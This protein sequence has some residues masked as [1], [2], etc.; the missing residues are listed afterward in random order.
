MSGI[1]A[2]LVETVPAAVPM[3]ICRH[4]VE[5]M[6]GAPMHPL[7]A[8]TEVVR[9]GRRL[10]VVRASLFDADREVARSMSVRLR[11]SETATPFDAERMRHTED[12]PPELPDGSST[13]TMP[14]SGVPKF[15]HG[16]ELR[17]PG[18]AFRTGAPGLL[19]L[20][21]HC[22]LVEGVPTSPYVRLAAVGDMLSMVAG[23]LDPG[24][25]LTIN[26][27]LD[28]HTFRDPVGE[29]IG[30]RGLH[31]TVGDGI[32]LSEAV[33]YDLEGRIGRGTAT[34]LIDHR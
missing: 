6:R 27:D 24:E 34:I 26:V 32:G 22:P 8:E 17:R 31:K 13:L 9:D 19:W 16:V 14:G 7:R 21:M 15:L 30:L 10:Q 33:L 4:T 18:G 23:Y 1:L 29:W 5:L 28:L 2:H 20:R 12:Q 11:I 3:R 25:W